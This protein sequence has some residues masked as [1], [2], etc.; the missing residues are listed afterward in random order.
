VHPKRLGF[1]NLRKVE[2]VVSFLVVDFA[3]DERRVSVA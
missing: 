1:H 2:D 3:L